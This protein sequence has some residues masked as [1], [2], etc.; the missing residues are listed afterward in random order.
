MGGLAGGI[1]TATS[2]D[3]GIR[4]A[5]RLLAEAA[6]PTREFASHMPQIVN[7]SLVSEIY[8]QFIPCGG[9]RRA[10][11]EWSLYFNVAMQLYPRHFESEA[12]QDAR[13]ADADR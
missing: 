4:N 9:R 3:R 5:W 1:A 6:Y 10:S 8:S 11:D 12:L 7:K 2:Y 13:L